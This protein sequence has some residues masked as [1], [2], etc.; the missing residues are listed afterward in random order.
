M[1][2]HYREQN[3]ISEK[4]LYKIQ[5][6][7]KNPLTF[8]HDDKTI[9]KMAD[10]S[11]ALPLEQV[12]H[13]PPNDILKLREKDFRGLAIVGMILLSLLVFSFGLNYGQFYMLEFMGQ[14]IM[15]DIRIQL[16]E[17]IQS[18][19]VAFFDRHP[20]G[21]LVTRVT[22]DIE[23]INE[24]FKSVIIT[25][26]KDILL[27]TGILVVLIYL[28]WRL[29]LVSFVIL[30]I[31]FAVTLLFS[32][33]AREAFRELRATIVK[34]N[35]FLQERFSGMRII[36]LFAREK[37]QMN[38]FTTINHENYMAGMKQIRIFAVF[39]PIIELLSSFAIALII[40]HGGIKTIED[41]LS[42]GSLVAFISYIQMFF[43][44]VRDISEKYNIMQLAMASIERVFEF[45]DHGEEIPETN[46]PILPV[47]KNGHL[48]FNNVYFGPAGC[49]GQGRTIRPRG[50]S[51]AGS[52]RWLAVRYSLCTP[53]HTPIGCKAH[54]ARRPAPMA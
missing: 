44:P 29:A 2:H 52:A 11:V 15:Q 4:R 3:F 37:Y 9:L 34:I 22:N 12:N 36:Q 18:R 40:W 5:M 17:K 19:A 7:H 1:L 41:Q 10:G 47:Y 28:N 25:V 20:V 39:F 48:Q 21:R 8:R 30:P 49:G 54:R 53:H 35:V 24:M 14:H 27:L 38:R 42:L 33:L 6:N 51:K 31:I 45:M 16:F 23:N 13:L 46:A 50:V 26:F 32:S 43:K